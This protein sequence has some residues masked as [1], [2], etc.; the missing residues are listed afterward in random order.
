MH[1][2]RTLL[3]NTKI[4]LIIESLRG[5]KIYK[6]INELSALTDERIEQT[7]IKQGMAMSTEETN[8]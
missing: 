8:T 7:R 3:L 6:L 5:K 2:L 1:P 4:K